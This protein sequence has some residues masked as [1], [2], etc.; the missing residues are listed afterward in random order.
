MWIKRW[1]EKSITELEN[2]EDDVDIIIGDMCAHFTPK[3]NLKFKKTW[4]DL[5]RY[6]LLAFIIVE[7]EENFE[8]LSEHI[9]D[10]EKLSELVKIVNDGKFF[11]ERDKI[12]KLKNINQKWSIT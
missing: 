1:N 8:H 6:N 7:L 9:G 10:K 3:I 2:N 5:P 11:E 4:R 12:E